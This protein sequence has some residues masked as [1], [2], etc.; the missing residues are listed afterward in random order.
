MG[1]GRTS[2]SRTR[3]VCEIKK[4]QPSRGDKFITYDSVNG[5]KE[6][7]QMTAATMKMNTIDLAD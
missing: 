5:P 3:T 4:I 2:K 1:N 7:Y 6:L